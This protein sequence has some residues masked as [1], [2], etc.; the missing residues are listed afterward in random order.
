MLLGASGWLIAATVHGS[1]VQLLGI[2]LASVGV[3][4]TFGVFWTVP[5]TGLS[6]DA[7]AAGLALINSVGLAGAVVSPT[8]IGLLHD[9]SH[10]YAIGLI[11]TAVMLVLGGLSMAFGGFRVSSK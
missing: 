6:E 1:I 11:Y 5:G 8:I 7:K 2:I 4:A 3:F 10:N 9:W